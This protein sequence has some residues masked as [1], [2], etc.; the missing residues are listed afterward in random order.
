[1]LE[2]FNPWPL[3]VH[4]QNLPTN[5]IGA[6]V[7]LFIQMHIFKMGAG[8]AIHVIYNGKKYLFVRMSHLPGQLIKVSWLAMAMVYNDELWV[9][10]LFAFGT[11]SMILN[12]PKLGQF[13]SKW[14]APVFTEKEKNKLEKFKP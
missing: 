13:L 12:N 14:A 5:Q 7:F 1:M 8:A 3:W 11:M 9:A 4:L 10:T 2:L 6:L